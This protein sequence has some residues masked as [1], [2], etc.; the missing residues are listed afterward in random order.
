MSSASAKPSAE[1]KPKVPIGKGSPLLT[2]ID[3]VKNKE[4]VK[5]EWIVVRHGV[6]YFSGIILGT[7]SGADEFALYVKPDPSADRDG[8]RVL[9]IGDEGSITVTAAA[10]VGKSANG[11]PWILYPGATGPAPLP[12]PGSGKTGPAMTA[13]TTVPLDKLLRTETKKTAE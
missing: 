1:K 10:D 6:R 8:V 7:C 2:P 12:F 9:V 3:M 4:D 11:M 5:S 13:E